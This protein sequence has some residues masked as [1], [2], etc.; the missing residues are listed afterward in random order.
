M[1]KVC[2]GF[3]W[4]TFVFDYSVLRQI[5]NSFKYS[6]KA[7]SFDLENW[8]L[9]VAKSVFLLDRYILSYIRI[10][11]LNWGGFILLSGSCSLS[12]CQIILLLSPPLK[13]TFLNKGFFSLTIDLFLLKPAMLINK[14]DTV[15]GGE[16]FTLSLPR[17]S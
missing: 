1:F 10:V 13:F 12:S 4:R 15:S 11:K 3:F 6:F 5:R 2:F 17:R 16:F 9:L 8:L 14:E 7:V